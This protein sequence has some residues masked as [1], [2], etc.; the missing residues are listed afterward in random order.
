MTEVISMVERVEEW[1][2]KERGIRKETLEGFRVQIDSAGTVTLPYSNGEKTRKGLPNGDRVFYFTKGTV[3]GLFHAHRDGRLKS[4]KVA[5]LVEGETDAMRLQQALTDAGSSENSAV[6]GL[7]GI[8]TWNKNKIHMFDNCDKVY[9]IFDNDSD[10]NVQAQVEASW[11][12]IRMDLGSKARR[13]KLPTDTKDIC[14][15]FDVYDL[16]A[17]RI[18]VAGSING[19]AQSRYK[20]L[21]LTQPP[22]PPNWLVEGIV[23]KGDVTLLTGAPGLGKSWFTM[24]LAV[25]VSMGCNKFL[26]DTLHPGNK[27]VLYIDQENPEDVVFTRLKRLGLSEEAVP[28]IRYLWNQGISLDRNCE[29]LLDEALDFE[30]TLVILDSLT[31]LHVQDEN[32]A[33][34]MAMLF[35]QAV[36]P[37]ARETGASL[38]LIHHHNKSGYTRG[39]GDIEASSDAVLNILPYHSSPGCFILKGGKSRRRLGGSS[40][41]VTIEDRDSSTVLLSRNFVSQNNATTSPPF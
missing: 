27:R 7:S 12:T 25:A 17:L 41:V 8:N 11:R 32:N 20:P 40:R 34:Q 15:F 24:G 26:G 39:S 23:A 16:D 38:M 10:Y 14:E 3:P 37:L 35:N 18:I 30:P 4:P 2:L 21:D 33:G 31:R 19:S 28:N 36:Q 29:V 13:V 9:I 1:F 6:Y 22:P 5:F